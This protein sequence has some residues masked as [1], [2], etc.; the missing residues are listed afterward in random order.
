MQLPGDRA[1][2]HPS[3]SAPARPWA[4]SL[5]S[6]NY[7]VSFDSEEPIAQEGYRHR[8]AS[9]IGRLAHRALVG[10][11]P[12][13]RVG[14]LLR[15][16]SVL[17][18]RGT[19]GF[20][21]QPTGD[22]SLT[23]EAS[24]F[25]RSAPR[26]PPREFQRAL[27]LRDAWLFPVGDPETPR[28][29]LLV[30]LP[31]W[32]ETTQREVEE[33][34]RDLAEVPARPAAPEG[35]PE[36][37]LLPTLLAL[38]QRVTGGTGLSSILSEIAESVVRFT[39]CDRSSVLL[40]SRRRRAY[41][42][43]ADVGTPPEVALAFVEKA[44]RFGNNVPFE[45][46]LREGLTVFF[47]RSIPDPVARELLET[48]AVHAQCIVPLIHRERG[49]G[50][51]TASWTEPHRL[52]ESERRLLTQ[53]AHYAAVAIDTS[54]LVE[55]ATKA[56]Q[57]RDALTQLS[58]TAHTTE[59]P[60]E[61]L[62][63]VAR[64]LGDLFRARWVAI[65]TKEGTD[66]V[67]RAAW[68]PDTDSLRGRTV[69]VQDPRSL[70][71][72]SYREGSLLFV[73]EAEPGTGLPSP[74]EASSLLVAPLLGRQD[75]LG[76]LVLAHPKPFRFHPD[77]AEEIGIAATIT[78]SAL[79]NATLL[80]QLRASSNALAEKTARLE[81]HARALEVKTQELEDL[82]ALGSHDL[83]APLI[84]IEGFVHEL[85][86]LLGES[87][88][89]GNEVQEALSFIRA[90]VAR[91]NSLVRTMVRLSDLA[92]RPDQRAWFDANEAVRDLLARKAPELRSGKVHVTCS[93]LPGVHADRQLFLEV[94]EHLLDNA[95]RALEG[96]EVRRIE[97][98]AEIH[99]E[100]VRFFVTDTGCGMAEREKESAFRLF[101]RG[102]R[103]LSRGSGT[104]LLLVRKILERH[105]GR[106]WLDSVPGVGTTVWISFPRRPDETRAAEERQ[107]TGRKSL[108][109]QE[110]R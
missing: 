2:L 25:V 88:G 66:L 107:E 80:T 68:G 15:E 38:S 81:E 1:S 7:A 77:A 84:N 69:S 98:G 12:A 35:G 106:A 48:L 49:L 75:I 63:F 45:Q 86:E 71:A 41:V 32:D 46:E 60:E 39:G 28:G 54:Q 18:L 56:A 76:V 87:P 99:R 5:L 55:R 22:E 23:V 37:E 94:F 100:E 26:R 105:G 42:P 95:L 62:R 104:G 51:L 3:C 44:F 8:L 89:A 31:C 43:A 4:R 10:N 17:R 70:L 16:G 61:V 29:A 47:D 82:L 59:D 79:E 103:D 24:F 34:C 74:F 96:R 78:A 102:A 85:G 33:L 11:Y 67:V 65:W 83:R 97:I 21:E 72:R 73:H 110:S 13:A 27:A 14:V 90:N 53:F 50:A 52:T 9:S 36:S 6:A 40:W 101:R 57:F 109:S 91:M 108:L 93:H 58:L 19:R 92:T 64:R 20:E 30:D